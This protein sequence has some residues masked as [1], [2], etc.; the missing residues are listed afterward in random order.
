MKDRRARGVVKSL[1]KYMKLTINCFSLTSD[2]SL[3]IGLFTDF[4]A[5]AVEF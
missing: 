4:S 2:N 3:T 5:T 1:N